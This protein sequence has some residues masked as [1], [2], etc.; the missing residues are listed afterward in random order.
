M[1]RI[2][3]LLLCVLFF[4]QTCSAE[5]FLGHINVFKANMRELPGRAS[6]I[7]DSLSQMQQVYIFDEPA[8]NKF[9]HVINIATNKEGYIHMQ[10]ID[11]DKPIAA[12]EPGV[13]QESGESES[14]NPDI[15]IIN[16]SKK[17][18]ILNLN[19]ESHYLSPYE[20]TKV[21]IPFGKL[22]Y[23]ASA[24]NVIP[25]SGIEYLKKNVK[26]TWRFYIVTTYR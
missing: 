23:Y 26:Y 13:F 10:L 1:K 19:G 15:E 4:S 2:Y 9:L 7:I 8:Q 14:V 18:L 12:N 22:N 5:A 11:F 24:V 25:N 21:T 6:N 16:D 3:L 17:E 20:K